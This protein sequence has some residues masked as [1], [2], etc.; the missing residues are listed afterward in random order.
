MRALTNRTVPL[1]II[2]LSIFI[3][4]SCSD[5]NRKTDA[6][7]NTSDISTDTAAVPQCNSGQL[8]QER[9]DYLNTFIKRRGVKDRD[10]ELQRGADKAF[11]I[12]F[13]VEDNRVVMRVRGRLAGAEPQGG[14][15]PKPKIQHLLNDID[16]YIKR[17]CADSLIFQSGTPLQAEPT[18]SASPG[19]SSRTSF[20][21][22]ACPFP[23]RPCT[24]GSCG[25]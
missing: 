9:A 5:P 25:C 14:G 22:E 11:Q 13:F 8:P 12:D 15:E 18:P 20:D 4:G 21:F 1:S 23:S 6:P 17:G 16:L 19:I 3:I 10:V 24:D 2:A 7:A